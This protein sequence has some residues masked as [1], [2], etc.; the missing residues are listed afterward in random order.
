M[1]QV[2]VSALKIHWYSVTPLSTFAISDA[3]FDMVHIDIVGPLPPSNVFPYLLTCIDQFTRWPE[4]IPIIDITAETL[5]RAFVSTW[6]GCF[7]ILLTI[8]ADSGQQFDSC[9]WNELM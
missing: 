4:D 2:H 3:C 5:A 6:M 8:S 7:S 9:L 1:H